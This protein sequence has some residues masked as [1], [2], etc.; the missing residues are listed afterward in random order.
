MTKDVDGL[1]LIYFWEQINNQSKINK[2]LIPKIIESFATLLNNLYY[3]KQIERFVV[4][5]IKA[6][7]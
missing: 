6:I 5:S 1:G 2:T 3:G 7:K 4:I